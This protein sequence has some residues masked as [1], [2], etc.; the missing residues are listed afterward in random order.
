[1]KITLETLRKFVREYGAVSIVDSSGE[2]RKLSDGTPDVWEL[3]LRADVFH[4]AGSQY[5]RAT[6]AKVMDR[7]TTKPGNVSQISC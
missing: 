5:S 4:F 1:V 2:V 6:F 7:M 3:A